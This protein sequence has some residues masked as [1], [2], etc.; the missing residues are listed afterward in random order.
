MHTPNMGNS[1]PSSCTVRNAMPE[2]SGLPMQQVCSKSHAGKDSCALQVRFEPQ[3]TAQSHVFCRS[4]AS[5]WSWRQQ[6]S[7]WI[8]SPQFV[9]SLLIVLVNHML[10]PEV[11]KIL[12]HSLG[13]LAVLYQGCSWEHHL[14][15]HLA[16]VIG[17]AVIIVDH[18]HG[19]F[20]RS[21]ICMLKRGAY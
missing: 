17:E 13:V 4:V 12:Q 6:N 14:A 10:T 21:A 20:F 9:N 2:S 5:T 3:S 1:P 18:D 7:S 11:P 16:Q 8:Q 19:P 15:P